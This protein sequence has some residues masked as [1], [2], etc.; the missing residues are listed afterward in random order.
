MFKPYRED[1]RLRPKSLQSIDI[2]P[3][4]EFM[5]SGNKGKY[6]KQ[7]AEMWVQCYPELDLVSQ[8]RLSD[9]TLHKID[10]LHWETKTIIEIDGGVFMRKGCGGRHGSGGNYRKDGIAAYLGY[11]VFRFTSNQIASM[12]K[13][14]DFSGLQIV[15]ETIK[16]RWID[17]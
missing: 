1:P 8:A 2:D 15:V 7:F 3:R 17:G 12:D 14:K 9:D 16:R 13:N 6:E 11:A 4:C 5:Q 10:F